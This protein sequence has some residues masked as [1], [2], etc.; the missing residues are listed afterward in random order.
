MSFEE[1]THSAWKIHALESQKVADEFVDKMALIES[2]EHIE[3]FAGLISHITGEHL[4]IWSDGISFLRLLKNHA[5]LISGTETEKVLVRSIA[6]LQLGAG[7]RSRSRFVFSFRS[8]QSCGWRE[9]GIRGS[10]GFGFGKTSLKR[11][12]APSM[13]AKAPYNAFRRSASPQSVFSVV[14]PFDIVVCFFGSTMITSTPWL[15]A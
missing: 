3:Q 10:L 6:S 8:S 1:Y 2:S 15:S 14:S 12:Q 4:G 5:L 9:L 11:T 7:V 13:A